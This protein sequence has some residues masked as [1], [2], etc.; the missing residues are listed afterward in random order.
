[1]TSDKRPDLCHGIEEIAKHLGLE[2]R[3]ARYL[4]ERGEL[5]TF[6]L[7]RSVCALRSK[8]DAWLLKKASEGSS[9]G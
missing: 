6:K 7:R 1:M 2:E 3:Q 4:H 5:P 9:H 8:L